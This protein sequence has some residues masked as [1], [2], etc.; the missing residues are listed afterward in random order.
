MND[1]QDQDEAVTLADGSG[2]PSR[3]NPRK[4]YPHRNRALPDSTAQES[5]QS[6]NEPYLKRFNYA[7]SFSGAEAEKLPRNRTVTGRIF[8][9]A[10]EFYPEVTLHPAA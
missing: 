5:Y 10:G 3:S 2:Y 9:M 4:D 1:L 8:G 7:T 6:G